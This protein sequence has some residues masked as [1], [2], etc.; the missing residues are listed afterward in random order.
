MQ[1]ERLPFADPT[2]SLKST[3]LLQDEAVGREGGEKKK[4][5]E[6]RMRGKQEEEEEEKRGIL[7]FNLG[8]E[9]VVVFVVLNCVKAICSKHFLE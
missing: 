1:R 8:N 2:P 5:K 4:K 9:R 6:E 7:F 3:N